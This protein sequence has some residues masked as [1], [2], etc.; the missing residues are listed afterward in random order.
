[1]PKL[2]YKQSQEHREKISISKKGQASFRGKKHSEETKRKIGLKSKGRCSG[3]KHPKWKGGITSINKLERGKFRWYIQKQVFERDDYTCQMCD[4]RGGKLQVDHIQSW[5]DYVE[6]RFEIDNCR[7]LCMDC[8]YFITFGKKKPTKI[9][10]WGHNYS[11]KD[12]SVVFN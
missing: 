9:V 10:S 5:K 4:K 8:H 3:S 2:G 7:T 6:L 12:K 11:R 1:M